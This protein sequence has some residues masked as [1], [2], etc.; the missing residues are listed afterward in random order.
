MN[1]PHWFWARGKTRLGTPH[2]K[3]RESARSCLVVTPPT[4]PCKGG[5]N[6]NSS[7]RPALALFALL[8]SSSLAPAQNVYTVDQ[9]ERWVFQQDGTAQMARQ[10]LDSHLTVHLDEVQRAC[11]LTE[12][13]KSKLRLAGR[14]DIK[15][16]FDRYE[17][18]RRTFKP[19]NQN[20][21]DFQEVWQKF[22][23]SISP[24]QVSL[25]GGLFEA[26]SLFEK[27][28]PSTLTPEQ[29][30]RFDALLNERRQ[31]QYQNAID[32]VVHSLD[33]VARLTQAQRLR[34]TEFLV[35]E[36]KPPSRF[37][38]NDNYYLL[39]QLG[40]LPEAKLHGLF[41][42]VQR[43]AIEPQLTQAQGVAASLRA[44]QLWPGDETDEKVDKPA[45]P[46]A[47]PKK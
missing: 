23:Q 36:T 22:W 32:N 31:F 10:R 19:I 14:G 6:T 1:A 24:L 5:E 12:A 2:C 45:R 15:H 26:D 39:W 25:Q 16:F 21:P 30:A 7:L 29:K 44:T 9:M 41:D 34:L 43:K 18:V 40:R 8:V 4:P 47:S 42:D 20:A 37:G 33:Q 35:K 11:Q 27:S 28:L 38:P 13:Q 17:T 46:A 3:T